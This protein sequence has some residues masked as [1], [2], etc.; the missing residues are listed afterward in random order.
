M[1]YSQNPLSNFNF[2]LPGGRGGNGK[3]K[4]W[5]L[6]IFAVVMV[7]YYKSSQEVVPFSGRTQLVAVSEEEIKPLAF[8]SY[9]RILAQ[10]K[11]IN[12]GKDLEFVRNVAQ[13]IITVTGRDDLEWELNLIESEEANAFALPGGKIAV[14]SGLLPIAKNESG[15]ATVIGHEVA[16]V[17]ARH[18]AERMTHEKFVQLGTMAVG[19]S[20]GDMDYDQQRMIMG[21]LGLGS[22]FGL[23]L[24]FSR[25][26]ESEADYIGLILLAKAC[27]DP[28]E[29]PRLWERMGQ[30]KTNQPAEFLSTHPATETRIRKLVGWQEEAMKVRA[31]NC[32]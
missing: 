24:P 16:H 30:A 9:Q 18:G 31:E 28:A 23:Q 19:M 5:P 17:I 7:Y 14:Y 26:H 4:I 21:A 13:K 6:L 29:A 11:I 20:V 12:S 25:K 2:R 1:A 3:F 27:L 8:S 22:Q 15:L 32:S 10:S